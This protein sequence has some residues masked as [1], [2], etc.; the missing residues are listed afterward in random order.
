M[1]EYQCVVVDSKVTQHQQH[2]SDDNKVIQFSTP[3]ESYYLGNIVIGGCTCVR[4]SA[5]GGDVR[6]IRSDTPLFIQLKGGIDLGGVHCHGV[7]FLRKEMKMR[8]VF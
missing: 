6:L 4:V 2:L 1:C 8:I 7:N 3:N 5:Y